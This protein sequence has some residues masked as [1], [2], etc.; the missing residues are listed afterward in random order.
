MKQWMWVYVAVAAAGLVQ[1]PS[2]AAQAPAP[3][4]AATAG[5]TIGAPPDRAQVQKRLE[6]VATLLENS[7]A[8]RQVEASRDGR[9]TERR[10][11]ARELHKAAAEALAKEDLAGASKLLQNA[12]AAMFE[13]VRFAAPEQVTA[14]KKQRDFDA[15]M[16]SARALLAAQQRISVEKSSPQG[17]ETTRNIEK[18]LREA[19]E[20]AAA[21]QLERGRATLDRAYLI[22][23]AAIGSMRSG[24]TLVRSLKFTSKQEEYHYELDRNETHQMLIK[25]LL[26]EK[27]AAAETDRMVTGFVDRARELRRQAETAAARG[28]FEAGIKSLEESTGELVRAIRNAGIYI[29]G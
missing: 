14:E 11:K 2:A 9:A 5:S 17:T 19:G 20:L 7:S 18:L 29:P 6:S 13:A 12:T 26:E 23:K 1:V 22:A 4:P 3:T 25:V 28:D 15:R 24:D 8:A 10:E 21:G 27:R 16:E